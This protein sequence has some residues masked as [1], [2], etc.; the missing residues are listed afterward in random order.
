VLEGDKDL[1]EETQ[2]GH[3][4][5][6]SPFLSSLQYPASGSYCLNFRDQRSLDD[7]IYRIQ[8]PL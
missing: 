1:Q 2:Q 4:K 8:F 3:K 7:T 5:Y 6:L